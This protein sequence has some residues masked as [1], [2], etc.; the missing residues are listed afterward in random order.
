MKPCS[1]VRP[2]ANT[3]YYFVPQDGTLFRVQ[4]AAMRE[5][6]DELRQKSPHLTFKCVPGRWVQHMR[7]LGTFTRELD[8]IQA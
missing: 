6:F 8:L 1:I 2:W 3:R 7:K 5:S 4:G